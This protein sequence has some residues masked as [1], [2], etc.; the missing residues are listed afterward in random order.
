MPPHCAIYGKIWVCQA[1][2]IFSFSLTFPL[3]LKKISSRTSVR[4]TCFLGSCFLL[5][6]WKTKI[7]QHFSENK[8]SVSFRKYSLSPIPLG[9]I[10]D[11]LSQSNHPTDVFSREREW[12]AQCYLISRH[13]DHAT[14]PETSLQWD[15]PY[16]IK[17]KYWLQ[18]PYGIITRSS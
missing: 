11:Y 12:S 4:E 5:K 1:L 7:S 3:S 17:S 10:I 13:Q 8:K 2:R 16:R 14:L 9:N 18:T 6:T 15:V